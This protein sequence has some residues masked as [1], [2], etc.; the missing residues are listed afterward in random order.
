MVALMV[1]LAPSL[2][3]QIQVNGPTG[4]YFSTPPPI[5]EWAQKSE[6]GGGGTAVTQADI[7]ALAD[8]TDASDGFQ[9]IETRAL[10]ATTP[11]QYIRTA[12]TGTLR[13]RAGGNAAGKLIGKFTNASAAPIFTFDFSY[14]LSTTAAYVREEVPLTY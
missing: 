3:A 4:A 9:V 6:L 12:E 11:V 2:D 13:I 8:A 7:D 5:E 14:K 10:S 1:G